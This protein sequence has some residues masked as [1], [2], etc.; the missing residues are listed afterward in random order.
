MYTVV[1]ISF[2][3]VVGHWFSDPMS[4][5]THEVHHG[6][7]QAD[8]VWKFHLSRSLEISDSLKDLFQVVSL[9]QTGD[10][11]SGSMVKCACKN[12]AQS[13]LHLRCSSLQQELKCLCLQ[14]SWK[15]VWNN[16]IEHILEV[17]IMQLTWTR[18]IS[19]DVLLRANPEISLIF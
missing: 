17:I 11:E 16:W 1:E 10:C 3:K 19:P 12:I 5:V 4:L 13:L 8:T 6:W 7:H 18:L 15:L 14:C 2:D 9:H